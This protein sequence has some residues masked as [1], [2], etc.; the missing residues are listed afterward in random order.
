MNQFVFSPN[1]STTKGITDS[2]KK[3]YKTPSPV[4][5]CVGSDLAV[6]DSLGPYIG[7][8][9]IKCHIKNTYVYGTLS[10]PITAKEIGTVYKTIKNIHPKSKILVIDAAVGNKEDIGV[11]KV[12]DKGIKPGLG[13]NKDLQLIGDVSIIGIVAE[14]DNA[15]N[16]I[17]H[18]T[19][20]SLIYKLSKIIVDGIMDYLS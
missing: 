11:I 6:G 4:I 10:H 14:N 19:R 9:L 15:L 5:I 3:I 20:F 12:T 18:T 17:L 16:N 13:V 1:E 7:S 2:L 8:E